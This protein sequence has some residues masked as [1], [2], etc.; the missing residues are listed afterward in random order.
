MK[1]IYITDSSDIAKIVAD[2]GVDYVMVDLEVNGKYER[3]GH[4]N[5]LISNH[6]IDSID[7][8]SKAISN[9]SSKLMVRL[10]PVYDGTAFEVNAA[11]D[12]GA[13]RLMLPM[14]RNVEEVKLFLSIVNKRV[15]VTL[16]LETASAYARLPSIL[17]ID[18]DFDIHVGLNDLH[19][20]MKLNF[21]FEL[22]V[23]GGVVEHIAMLCRNAKRNF[24][25]GGVSRLNGKA[26]LPAEDILF[27]HLRLGSTAVILG[28]DWRE[29]VN[30]GDFSKCVDEVREFL[31]S[32]P[33]NDSAIISKKIEGV[34]KMLKINFNLE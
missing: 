23:K 18:D 9:S 25:I 1:L 15:P 13:S 29:S 11:I 26:A 19:L 12:R 34:T 22:L 8:V 2:A 3:Q 32:E 20:E 4:L 24:G 33:V 5:T 17:R 28:R 6:Q 14:F 10:N 30:N 27:E 31:S 16:L 7:L 21:M